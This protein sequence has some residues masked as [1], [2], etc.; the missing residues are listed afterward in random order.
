MKKLTRRQLY[1]VKQKIIGLAMIIAGTILTLT[2]SEGAPFMLFVVIG[3]WFLLSKDM[4]WIDDY[5]DEVEDRKRM[6]RRS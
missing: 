4:I 5:H 1:F 6:R 2:I 3:L